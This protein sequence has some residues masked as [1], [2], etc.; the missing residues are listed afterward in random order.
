MNFLTKIKCIALFTL[1]SLAM[2]Q[3]SAQAVEKKSSAYIKVSS[4][5]ENGELKARYTSPKP[6]MKWKNGYV[7]PTKLVTKNTTNF[8]LAYIDC[9]TLES[10]SLYQIRNGN[11]G[12]L[13]LV[14]TRNNTKKPQVITSFNFMCDNYSSSDNSNSYKLLENYSLK[15][16][17]KDGKS[18]D[19]EIQYKFLKKE[20]NVL[21][22]LEKI[23]PPKEASFDYSYGVNHYKSMSFNCLDYANSELFNIVEEGDKIGNPM[24]TRFSYTPNTT[25]FPFSKEEIENPE[26]KQY[27]HMV[28]NLCSMY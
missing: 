2:L 26:N 16:I 14:N 21:H 19:N 23:Q 25:H 8:S 24:I 7:F 15:W 5:I 4:Q 9:D 6:L 3:L 18:Y 12:N 17:D 10:T 28:D 13:E 27:I 22:I 11:S 20:G 1:T